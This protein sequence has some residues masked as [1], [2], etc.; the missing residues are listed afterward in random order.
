MTNRPLKKNPLLKMLNETLIDLPAPSN[1]SYM[2][3]MGSILSMCLIVQ[4][5]SGLLLASVYSPSM[6]MSFF[7]TNWLMETND[8]G[9][10]LRYLHS[11][12]A[13]MFFMALYTHTGRNIYYNSFYM[14]KTW[15]IGIIML[16]LVMA[17]AFM[18][19]VLP[20]NQMSFWGASV[21]TNLF[22]EIPYI[23]P[24]VVLTI[25]GDMSVSEPTITRFFT[26]HFLLPFVTL[27]MLV[28][29]I[30]MLH[31]TGS[32]NP[33]GL[34][35]NPD[36]ILFNKYFSI[37][38]LAGLSFVIF[39]YLYV[40]LIA[41]LITGDNDNFVPANPL[42]T[43]THIQP[44]WYFLF[45]YA[46]LRSIPSKLGGILALTGSI[47]I[48]F[49]PPLFNAPLM[50]SK[51]FYPLAKMLFWLLTMN[52]ILLSWLGA[53]PVEAPF[54]SLSQIFTAAYFI[55]FV[56]NPLTSYLWDKYFMKPV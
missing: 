33:T 43:P 32:S 13:S 36:K 31:Q 18:G 4:V 15:N 41:P 23:G 35:S 5:L 11:N 39:F 10:L 16:V 34:N 24:K 21:I 17:T 46:I 56:L 25:W 28:V 55:N 8:K 14:K 38:D 1:L 6:D 53:R 3:N 54:L 2:W 37:K 47:L 52:L 12:G 22:S 7:C 50:K 48:L 42:T 27:S 44:E 45:A 30:T 29:H 51:A 40:T 9:W 49:L 26:F 20:L 19:Y